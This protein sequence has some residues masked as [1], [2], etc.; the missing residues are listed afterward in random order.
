M[1]YDSS[2]DETTEECPTMA[3]SDIIYEYIGK[4][5]FGFFSLAHL[6]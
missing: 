3:Y 5:N 2:S 1:P 4:R 6:I